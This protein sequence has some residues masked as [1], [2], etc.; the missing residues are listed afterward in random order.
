M[1]R[2]VPQRFT[3]HADIGGEP[4]QALPAQGRWFPSSDLIWSNN[5]QS[6]AGLTVA[7]GKR[8]A[9]CPT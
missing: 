1:P 9:D 5:R 7:R 2:A 4:R 3:N 6:G 8:E